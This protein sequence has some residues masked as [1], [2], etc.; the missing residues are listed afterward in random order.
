MTD[1]STQ[2][3]K[4]SIS[5]LK[6]SIAKRRRRSIIKHLDYYSGGDM[7][8]YI[9]QYFRAEIFREVPTYTMNI[10]RKFIN[11]MSRI[12]NLKPVRD[13]SNKYDI[14]T[15][16]KD[17]RFKHIERMTRLLGTIAMQVIWKD[18]KGTYAPCFDYQPVYYFQP[19]FH[20]ED[21]YKPYAIVYP[22]SQPTEDI[23]Y[24]EPLKYVYFDREVRV[25]FTEDGKIQHEEPNNYGVLPFVFLHRE[26]QIDS[27]FVEGAN[28][29]INCNEHVNITMTEMQLGLRFQMFG[30]P[31]A[32]G[33][34]AD[35]PIARVGSDTIINLPEGSNF[36][37][38][39]PQ[40][41]LQDVISNVKFQI[42]L[43]A[44]ANHLWVHWAEQGGEMPSGI[45]LIIKDFERLE[46]YK[47]DIEL[48]RIY[49]HDIYYLEKLIASFNE[50]SLPDES[51]FRIRFE[52]PEYPRSI[53]EILMKHQW[54]LD[55]G[56]TTEADI[57]MSENKDLSFNEAMKLI[58][59]NKELNSNGSSSE[60]KT[61]ESE[62]NA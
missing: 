2:I 11:K 40:G 56:Q 23:S 20:E 35:E 7:N 26:D 36:G 43:V 47:D 14:L 60:S 46:D 30:Q 19:Y 4:E 29:V 62:E 32:T 59:K 54:D 18:E 12:Y 5:D 16:K 31:F 48:W 25:V 8:Q 37:I 42:E 58:E 1:I 49:E 33:V 51:K 6:L 22:L 21:P 34:Y 13:V 50:T 3:I 53:Q 17:V 52:E 10:T 24:N 9:D 27:F 57:L 41:N 55:H 45:S 28:D 39:S 61:E 44:Q 15:R 38:A